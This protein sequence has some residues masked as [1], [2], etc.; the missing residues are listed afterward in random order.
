MTTYTADEPEPWA[1][2]TDG[3]LHPVAR[4]VIIIL[5]SSSA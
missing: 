2:I 5:T 4:N 1:A 3:F